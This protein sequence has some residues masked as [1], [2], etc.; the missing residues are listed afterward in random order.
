MEL[1]LQITIG[2]VRVLRITE[3]IGAERVRQRD[4]EAERVEHLRLVP[5]LDGP[6]GVIPPVVAA[7]MADGG[8]YQQNV[9]QAESHQ[10][11]YEYKAGL[12]LTL[13]NL[14]SPDETAAPDGD[15][16]HQVPPS[17]LNLDHVGRLTREIAQRSASSS[18]S[19]P[20]ELHPS[21]IGSEIGISLTELQAQ[22]NFQDIVAAAKKVAETTTR[23]MRELPMSPKIKS[24]EVVAT[25]GNARDFGRLLVAR[26]WQ[27]G[28]FQAERKGFVADGGSW[29]W[30]LFETAFKAFEFEGI[31]DIIHAVTYVYSAAL[32]DRSPED[33]KNI[34][35]RW[36]TWIW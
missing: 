10:H 5:K 12:C 27:S 2:P 14:K 21:E 6:V 25:T 23:S 18:L 24:R 36:I 30:T 29:L 31:L 33:G 9:E 11:W 20:E 7:V 34:Y 8:R 4:R 13:G 35:M 28:L 16:A 1:L 32:A 26:A 22:T 17:L 3:R 15:P 19:L